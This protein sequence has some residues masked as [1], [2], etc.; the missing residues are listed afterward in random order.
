MAKKNH[1]WELAKLLFEQGKS[2]GE[3]EKSTGINKGSVSREAK[4]CNWQ[5]SFLQ[6]IEDGMARVVEEFATLTQPQQVIVANNV[7]KKLKAK[8]LIKQTSIALIERIADLIPSEI[9]MAKLKAGMDA[10][11]VAMKTT[12]VVDYYPAQKGAVEPA[13]E[14]TQKTVVFEVVRPK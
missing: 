13:A 4:K 12:G 1:D 3:I 6:P 2:L 7:E 14:T 5:K 9:D 8:G 11:N 10:L